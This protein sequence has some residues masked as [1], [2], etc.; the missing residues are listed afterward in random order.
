[1]SEY[2]SEDVYYWNRLTNEMTWQK[3]VA[4][5][6]LRTRYMKIKKYMKI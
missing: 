3:P 1:M 6:D 2:G 5:P 4:G